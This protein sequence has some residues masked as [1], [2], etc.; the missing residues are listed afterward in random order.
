MNQP[1]TNLPEAQR[2][3][4]SRSGFGRL[5]SLPLW[6]RLIILTGAGLISLI[7]SS[8][9]FSS[10]LQQ[11]ADRTTKMK[12]LFDVA[13]TAGDAHVTFGELRYWLT[14]LS[15]SLLVTSERSATAAQ[16]RLEASLDRLAGYD[17]ETVAAIRS[18]VAAYVATAF[19]A[20]DVYTDGN[21]VIGN[22][23]L[24]SAR[25]H[26]AKV[27]EA[28]NALV[29]RAN[30]AAV[31]EREIVVA[32][33]DGSARAA[34]YIVIVLSLVGLGLTALVFRS[35]VTPLQ[36][37]NDA[38][39]ALMQG[40]Y[41]VEIPVEG[42][43][44][45]GAMARTLGLFREN[46]IERERLEAEAERQRNM[47]ATAIETIS[48]GFVLYDP[49]AR[50]LLANSKY[51]EMFPQIAEIVQPGVSFREILEA[52]VKVGGVEIGDASADGWVEQR[53]ARHRETGGSVDERR[54]GN[55]WVRITKR[56]TPDGGKVAV[57]T[58]ITE[59]KEREAEITSARDDAEAALAD[60]TKAQ[61]R[62]IQAEKM[63]SL[64]Q[65]TAGI[66]HEIKNPLNFVNNFA[67]LSDELLGMRPAMTPKICSRP[68]V[69]T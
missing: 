42:D 28:L 12:E 63:A 20:A 49:E 7:G 19:D 50:L 45:F 31:A 17:P 33:A 5:A 48:D 22:T 1:A 37:L 6:V 67:K 3:P 27:D 24:A 57:Y 13:G 69:P 62:L 18:E 38:I 30:A 64:G 25:V 4:Q 34:F 8:L 61:E 14:D 58:D 65:L 52:Q 15:V 54:Y 36:R 29:G 46:A 26:S 32:R 43:N 56:Q 2:R 53:L 9:Y 41:D 66:A 39:S 68:S 10:V 21:R 16:E 51:R 60:L 55:T 44:E 40:R 47:I 59:L 23:F 11:T 35:I